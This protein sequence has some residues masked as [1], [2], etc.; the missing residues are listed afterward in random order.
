MAGPVRVVH[1]LNQFFAGIGGEDAANR[2]VEVHDGPVGAG[3]ALQ[4]TLGTNGTIVATIVGG[5]NFVAEEG[6]R[7]AV[8]MREALGRLTPDVVVA[9]PAFD[10]GRYGLACARAC[11]EAQALGIKAVTAMYPDNPGFTTNRHDV[12][13]LPTST[14]VAEMGKAMAA[15]ARLALKLGSGRELGSADEE[16][17]LW[18]G[19]RRPVLREKSGAA[20]AVDMALDRIAGRP[21]QTE[22][23]VARYD[24]VTPTPPVPDL[25]RVK[26]GVVTSGGLVPKGNPDRLVS[27]RAERFFRYPLTDRSA[28]IVGEWESVHGGYSTEAVNTRNPNYVVPLDALRELEAAGRIGS[29]HPIYYATVGNQTAVA[30]AK[31]MG[32]EIAK[33]LHDADVGAVLLVAT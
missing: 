33:E 23:P 31:R 10:S 3:R 11:I 9:G 30:E 1:Y 25:S 15:L 17:Y 29:L 16:G 19:F 28:L 21:F 5:D 18:R 14:N 32:A 7:A 8:A 26:L 2:P 6:E 22:I 24:A 20:R 4:Q 13:C 12:I 27:A